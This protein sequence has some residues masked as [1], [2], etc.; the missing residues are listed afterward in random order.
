MN[1]S[2]LVVMMLS[3]ILAGSSSDLFAAEDGAG[4]SEAGP[5]TRL[6]RLDDQARG[7][8][9]SS[10]KIRINKDR[11]ETVGKLPIG[12]PATVE[13]LPL[14]DGRIVDAVAQEPVLEDGEREDKDAAANQKPMRALVREQK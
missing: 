7:P 9:D 13:R 14:S 11:F 6:I 8:N 5:G 3:T 10:R 12:A 1:R 4:I 2:S